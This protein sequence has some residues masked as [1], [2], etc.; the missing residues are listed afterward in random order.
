MGATRD[1]AGSITLELAI[2]APVLLLLL[3]LLIFA[4]RVGVA[5]S[6]VDHT[7][8]VAARDASMAR[9]ADGARNAANEAI[10]RELGS[11]DV[12]CTSASVAVDATGFSASLGQP[13]VVQVT[14]TCVVSVA[15]LALPGLPGQRV[16]TST[17]VSPLD[18]HRGRP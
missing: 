3:G 10:L 5:R 15:D 14:V 18:A 9:S 8:A 4:G 6:A 7:A 1:D 13:A 12:D 16:L 2:L 17:F 11:Q